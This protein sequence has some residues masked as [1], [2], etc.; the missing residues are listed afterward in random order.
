MVVYLG[1]LQLSSLPSAIVANEGLGWH[2]WSP[3]HVINPGGDWLTGARGK[4][5]NVYT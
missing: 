5:P 1:L 3:K 2:P 4:Q